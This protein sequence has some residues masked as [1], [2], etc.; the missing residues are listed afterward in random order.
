MPKWVPPDPDADHARARQIVG[1]TPESRARWLLSLDSRGDFRR[2]SQPERHAF[3]AEMGAFLGRGGYVPD[4]EAELWLNRIRAGVRKLAAG[5]AWGYA[6]V[7]HFNF[8]IPR[9]GQRGASGFESV[10]YIEPKSPHILH[11][12]RTLKDRMAHRICDT[13]AA[14]GNRLR[15][16]PRQGCGRLFVRA[17]R[18]QYCSPQCASVHRSRR[19][20]ARERRRVKGP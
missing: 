6:T 5:K 2:F 17:K 19:Y 15:R 14:V 1:D 13:L 20:R 3:G 11:H 9:P 12:S 4:D 10:G 16:C 8:W 18:Q 7:T